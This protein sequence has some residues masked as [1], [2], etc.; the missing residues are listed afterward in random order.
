MRSLRVFSNRADLSHVAPVADRN[1]QQT[2]IV[3]GKSPRFGI[4]RPGDAQT[5]PADVWPLIMR[6]PLVVAAVICLVAFH[7]SGCWLV[8]LKLIQPT[9]A[10]IAPLLPYVILARC[11]RAASA[12]SSSRCKG[13]LMLAGSIPRARSRCS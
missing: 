8:A 3:R 7:A 4:K 10:T 13:V 2:L 5:V 11:L 1:R 6:R 9:A 12:A